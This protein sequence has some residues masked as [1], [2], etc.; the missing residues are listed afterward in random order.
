MHNVIPDHSPGSIYPDWLQTLEKKYNIVDV[1]NFVRYDYQLDQL[2]QRLLAVKKP[3]F[4]AHDRIVAVH[5]DTDYYIQGR[6]GV[7]LTNL[8]TIWQ[9]ADIPFHTMLLY[10]NHTGIQKEIDVLCQHRPA[11]DRPTIV[12]TVINQLSYLP[13]T[14]DAEPELDV[15]QIEYHGLAL[16]GAQRS[17]R[18]ALYNHIKQH[19][20]QIAMVI[21]AAT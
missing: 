12:E 5:F 13:D 19:C 9:E 2:K 10:T 6:V 3:A 1:F 14:Y 8:F 11:I 17:H 15:D 4:D 20:D 7:N 18:Y 21:K 16:M